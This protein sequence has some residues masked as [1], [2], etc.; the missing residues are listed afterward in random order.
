MRGQD[1]ILGRYLETLQRP[2]GLTDQQFWRPQ[3]KSCSFLVCDGLL[4]KRGWKCGL[5]PKRV[6]GRLE[7]R[8]EAIRNLH[9]DH[10]HRGKQATYENVSRRYQWK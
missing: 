1:L 8:L 3:K 4:F 5:P 7:Q 9:D 6:L 2:D 10:G